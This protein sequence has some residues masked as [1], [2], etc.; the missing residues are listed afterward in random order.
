MTREMLRRSREQ[1]AVAQA[2]LQQKFWISGTLSFQ[3]DRNLVRCSR[4]AQFLPVMEPQPRRFKM[5]VI[6]AVTCV[7]DL[8]SIIAQAG[9]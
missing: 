6:L 2:L 4:P 3:N 1:I 7:L 5:I 9:G 8:S